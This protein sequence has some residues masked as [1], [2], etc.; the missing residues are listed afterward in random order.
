[1]KFYNFIKIC[2]G[3]TEPSVSPTFAVTPRL[4]KNE[5]KIN[6][7]I[8]LPL[9]FDCKRLLSKFGKNPG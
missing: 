2:K 4:N 7:N 8:P 6:K 5:E 1:M 9:S 3:S